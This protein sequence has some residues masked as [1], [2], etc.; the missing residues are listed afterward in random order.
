MTVGYSWPDGAV[1]V[2]SLVSFDGGSRAEVSVQQPDRYGSFH[3]SQQPACS[4]ARGA[5]LS[6]S[7]ASFGPNAVTVDLA[8]FNRILDFDSSAGVVEVEAELTRGCCSTFS[9]SGVYLPVSWVPRHLGRWMHCCGCSWQEFRA[10]RCS[11]GRFSRFACSSLHGL[12]EVSPETENDLFRA[13][14]GAS[15]SPD[16]SDGLAQSRAFAS[17]GSPVGAAFCVQPAGA[18]QAHRLS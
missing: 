7:A 10:R 11:S 13:T 2:K 4:I 8:T 17:K 1:A 16:H 14:C 5:G 12:V 3:T 6:F 18:R 9:R 15:G